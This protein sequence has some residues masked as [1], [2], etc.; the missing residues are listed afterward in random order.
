MLV[1]ASLLH[2]HFHYTKYRSYQQSCV[3]VCLKH[4]CIYILNTFFFNHCILN[5]TV[6]NVICSYIK[7]KLIIFLLSYLK[8]LHRSRYLPKKYCN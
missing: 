4:M 3:Y 8:Q 7:N 5:G 6:F 2:I 1:P